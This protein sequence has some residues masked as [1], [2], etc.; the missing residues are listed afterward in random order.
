M[1]SIAMKHPLSPTPGTRPSPSR[2]NSPLQTHQIGRLTSMTSNF[3]L[4]YN[5]EWTVGRASGQTVGEV[6]GGRAGRVVWAGEHAYAPDRM[7]AGIAARRRTH[8][9]L[10]G[11]AMCHPCVEGRPWSMRAGRAAISKSGLLGN[12]PTLCTW[13]RQGGGIQGVTKLQTCL[14]VVF[15]LFFIFLLM[16]QDMRLHRRT[17]GWPVARTRGHEDL[18]SQT[19]GS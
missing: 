7:L 13:A 15:L 3:N 6:K 12:L 18:G 1:V 16:N 14:C 9:G 4:D 17:E 11:L 2:A 5:G 19:P 10:A 8:G